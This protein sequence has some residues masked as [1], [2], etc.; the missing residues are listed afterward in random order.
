MERAA[1][2]WDGNDPVRDAQ[3]LLPAEARS[4]REN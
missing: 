4:P 3:A 1:S 2:N